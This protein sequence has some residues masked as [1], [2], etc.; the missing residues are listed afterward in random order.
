MAKRSKWDLENLDFDPYDD[1]DIDADDDMDEFAEIARD[2]YSTD[3]E[4]PAPSGRRISARRKIERRNELKELYSQ[5]DDWDD[6][7]PESY[8]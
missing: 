5:F 4:D 3:W 8:W 6:I 1:D 2:I 7:G